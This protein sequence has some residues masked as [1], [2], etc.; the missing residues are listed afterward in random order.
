VI[1][2]KDQMT[3]ALRQGSDRTPNLWNCA[4]SRL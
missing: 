3:Y 4:I 1:I 2:V